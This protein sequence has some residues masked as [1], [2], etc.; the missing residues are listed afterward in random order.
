MAPMALGDDERDNDDDDDDD[1]HSS[2]QPNLGKPHE[3]LRP[4]KPIGR[5]TVQPNDANI[6]E[7]TRDE[8][9]KLAPFL[10]NSPPEAH[11]EINSAAE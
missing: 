2:R 6:A 3:A 5:S 9:N 1:E 4:P 10:S 8:D 11:W 7:T